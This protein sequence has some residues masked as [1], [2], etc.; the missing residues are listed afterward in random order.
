[1]IR[2]AIQTARLHLRPPQ[3]DDSEWIAAEIARPEVHAML[4]SLP[5]PYGLTEARTWL[6]GAKSANWHYVI[7]ADA[8]LGVVTLMSVAW[9][10]ELGYWLRP[11]AWGKGYMTEAARAVVGA[12]FASGELELHSGHLTENKGSARVLGQ[13]GFRYEAPLMRH[14][15][16][17]GREVEVQRMRLTRDEFVPFQET[18][19][20]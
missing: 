15:N 4:P 16:Y 14:S 20:T 12:W 10:Q 13:L 17:F 7:V 5:C 8:P 11:S 18:R 3:D 6:N 1:M 2:A 19:P 9:G